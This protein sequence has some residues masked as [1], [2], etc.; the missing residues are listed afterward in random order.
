MGEA[1]SDCGRWCDISDRLALEEPVTAEERAFWRWHAES[2]PA[3]GAEQAAYAELGRLEPT[4]SPLVG[5]TAKRR[6]NTGVVVAGAAVLAVAASVTL[7]FTPNGESPT[8]KTVVAPPPPE[9]EAPVALASTEQTLT[10]SRDECLAPSEGVDVCV[11]AGAELR[12][13]DARFFVARGRVVFSRSDAAAEYPL[14]VATHDGAIEPL[15]TVFSVD[16]REDQATAVQLL[17]GT[18][19]LDAGGR[20]TE[21]EEGHRIRLGEDTSEELDDADRELFRRLL[22]DE[23]L[24]TL[25]GPSETVAA[26]GRIP[27]PLPRRTETGPPETTP[28][29]AEL[30]T[31]ARRA[32][33][34][35][36]RTNA[37]AQYTR[38]LQAHPGSPEA[39]SALLTLGELRLALGRPGAALAAFER[40][41]RRG[42]LA[43]EAAYGR[44]RALRALGRSSE[45][46]SETERFLASYPNHLRAAELRHR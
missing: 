39:R 19:R 7:V 11:A 29:P 24:S 2:C 18:L 40:Y 3:C 15:G 21:L 23:I 26:I 9:P 12:I 25:P 45:A 31:L 14:R 13:R 10:P 35:G 4:A 42:A 33:A 20:V 46:S 28:T 6:S 34:S 38:L 37:E 16:A 36:D 5:R 1:E 43:P 41:G 17:S 44:I 22:P 27:R 32:M 8:A 30:L